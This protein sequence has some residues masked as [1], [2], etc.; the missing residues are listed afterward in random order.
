MRVK[1]NSS[2]RSVVY[3][4]MKEKRMTSSQQNDTETRPMVLL[5]GTSGMSEDWTGIVNHLQSRNRIVIRP[6]YLNRQNIE[7]ETVAASL[8]GA[9]SAVL[10]EADRK[11]VGPFDLVGYSL[12]AGVATFIAAEHPEMVRSLVLISGFSHCSDVWMKLQFSLWLDL[13]RRDPKALTRLLVL[14]G[15]SKDFLSRFDVDTLDTIIENF[16]ASSNWGAIEQSIRL[17]L[18]LDVRE[19]ARKIVAPTLLITAKDD[20]IVPERNSYPFSDLIPAARRTEIDSGHLSFL[21]Q[22][23]HL[24]SA[25]SAFL[26]DLFS[27]P[28]SESTNPSEENAG[29]QVCVDGNESL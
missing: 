24:A 7:G 2:D 11:T 16:A 5:H 14:N 22:P 21:E 12:G 29:H 25:I 27:K 19:A 3:T 20:Q 9:A 6:D 17:D 1:W 28:V 26:D 18:E 4:H 10:D 8:A 23:V 15:C 13:A